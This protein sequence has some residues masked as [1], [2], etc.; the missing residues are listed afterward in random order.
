[1]FFIK[2]DGI[3]LLFKAIWR[4]ILGFW[5]TI[6]A[7]LAKVGYSFAT[8]IRPCCGCLVTHEFKVVTVGP[9]RVLPTSHSHI[10]TKIMEY[11]YLPKHWINVTGLADY[12][13]KPERFANNRFWIKLISWGNHCKYNEGE[14]PALWKPFILIP[15]PLKTRQHKRSQWFSTHTRL[16]PTNRHWIGFLQGL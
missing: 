6:N 16:Q 10:E 12:S 9:D 15:V 4:K 1:M 3:C 13:P 2:S 8:L 11:N 7:A 14:A 5:Q